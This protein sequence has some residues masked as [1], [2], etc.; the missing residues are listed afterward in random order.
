MIV[1]MANT[2]SPNGYIARLNGEED[3]LSSANWFDFLK[4]AKEFDNFVM[5]RETYELVMRLYKDH[6]FDSVDVK[7]KV[8]VTRQDFKAPSNYQV[9][10]S[11]QEAVEFLEGEGLEK[12]FL[13]GGGKLNAE[14]A[15]A[16]LINEISL[17]IEPYMIGEGRQ[18]LASGNYEFPLE[19]K[20][21]EEL[22]G[23]RVRLVYK[24]KSGK[25]W[26]GL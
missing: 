4:E 10:H 22:S 11:P 13:V 15:K 20:K 16:G 26:G 23:G 7:Y 21:T 12:I 24:V 17:T 25:N 3:W 5:G 9:V 2:I 18:V 6:N 19:L 8:I 14:F 1:R